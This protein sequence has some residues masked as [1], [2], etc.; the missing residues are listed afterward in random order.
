MK[1]Y[2]EQ[3]SPLIDFINQGRVEIV[4]GTRSIDEVFAKLHLDK[5][6]SK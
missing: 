2:H 5:E 3:T 1:V 4:D 6:F